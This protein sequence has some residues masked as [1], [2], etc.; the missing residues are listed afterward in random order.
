MRHIVE[1]VQSLRAQ[2]ESLGVALISQ[3]EAG[4][5]VMALVKG[6]DAA[7]RRISKLVRNR[8]KID[9]SYTFFWFLFIIQRMVKP[10]V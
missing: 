8:G 5:A 4:L 7:N 9:M 6:D 10:T 3:T 2:P 1:A